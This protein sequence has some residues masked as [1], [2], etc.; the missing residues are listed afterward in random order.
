MF[1]QTLYW[2]SLDCSWGRGVSER[3][4]S[5]VNEEKRGS[6][7]PSGFSNEY[8]SNVMIRG[9]SFLFV[10]FAAV[11]DLVVENCW[12]H[13]ISYNSFYVP[14]N[15]LHL[16]L[17]RFL[18]NWSACHVL[19]QLEKPCAITWWHFCIKLL[20]TA[21]WALRQCHCLCR[22]PVHCRPGTGQGQRS[23]INI[24]YTW[25]SWTNSLSWLF[26]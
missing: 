12:Q 19:V 10:C 22:A 1:L 20:T 8:L 17:L 26:S 25:W 11:A 16:I 13:N 6:S 15:R 23:D 14:I 9:L 5:Q 24:F 21:L 7:L 18:W 4:M 2:N 3:M